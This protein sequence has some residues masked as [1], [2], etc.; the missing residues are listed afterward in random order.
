MRLGGPA[1]VADL[2][3]FSP[4]VQLTTILVPLA[5]SVGGVGADERARLV[6]KKLWEGGNL[7]QF[8]EDEREARKRANPAKFKRELRA[9]KKGGG[10]YRDVMEASLH[11]EGGYSLVFD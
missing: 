8:E 3:A 10:G 4:Q 2:A 7:A 9:R 11:H 5:E 6:S 1:E